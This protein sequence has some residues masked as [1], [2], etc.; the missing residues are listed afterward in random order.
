L[1]LVAILLGWIIALFLALFAIAFHF[2]GGPVQAALA[3]AACLLALPPA[4]A[5]A[6]MRGWVR[7]MAIA[8][9]LA[10]AVAFTAL[11]PATSIY[12]SP[13][14]EA[15]FH[16][17]YAEKLTAWPVAY[18]N[19]WI[20]TDYGR[21]HVIVSGPPN[22]PPVLLLN[23]S[24]LSGWSWIHNIEPLAATHRV[25]AIDNIGEVGLNEM[26][27]ATH[28]PRTGP[29]ITAYYATIM[30]T[31]GIERADIVG[32]SIGGFIATT[33]AIGMPDRVRRLALLCPMGFGSTTRT[34]ALMTL[35]QAFPLPA[36]Q[37]LAF[38]WALGEEAVTRESFGEWFHLV[39]DGSIPNPVPPRSF[40]PAELAS[41]S[42]PTLAF[43]GTKD[44][45]VGDAGAARKLAQ[46]TPGIEI[47][48]VES[49]HMVGVEKALMV[50]AQLAE[51]LAR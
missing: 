31:L 19:A 5:V 25:Y 28:V 14:I 15:E 7:T 21:V 33:L 11:T 42:A 22:A 26:S 9:L 40:T 24:A 45:V 48:V 39:L 47:V 32:A 13:E 43:F 36:V 27:D 38:R 3:A 8:G 1:R 4:W 30:D 17:L 23:A 10:G 35:A 18:E 46:N 41:I 50:N 16:R 49:G 51:F 20:D 6:R 2:M 44:A 12:K 34:V 37:E 29:E